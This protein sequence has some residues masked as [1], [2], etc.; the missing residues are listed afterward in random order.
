MV[1]LIHG[2]AQYSEINAHYHTISTCSPHL[3]IEKIGHYAIKRRGLPVFTYGWE[4][5]ISLW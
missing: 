1:F 5:R 3:D 4:C 2:R